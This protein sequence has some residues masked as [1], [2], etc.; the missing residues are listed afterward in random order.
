M[1]IE[2]SAQSYGGYVAI[3][4]VGS[5]PTGRTAYIQ[6]DWDFPAL[7]HDL[8]MAAHEH[9]ETDGT[10]DCPVCG[11]TVADMI[12]AAIDWLDDHD[13]ATVDIDADSGTAY[14]LDFDA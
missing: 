1:Q 7:A 2:L 13:G 5:H 6:S 8:G 10:V 12:S 14:A 3:E 4:W 9:G 11:E